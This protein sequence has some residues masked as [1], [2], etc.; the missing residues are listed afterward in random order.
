[1]SQDELAEHIGA[2]RVT[3]S[4]YETGEFLPSVPAL[5]R[6]ADALFTTPAALAG[7]DED[8][9]PLTQ[10]ARFVS[11]GMDKLTKEQRDM[12]VGVVCAMFPDVFKRGE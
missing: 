8:A 10:E 6:I 11:A 9:P 2:N 1:M 5:Q 7:N 4:R 12:I 3:V